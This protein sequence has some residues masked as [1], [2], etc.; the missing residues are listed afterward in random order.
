MPESLQNVVNR[1]IEE[2]MRSVNT[3]ASN[4]SIMNERIRQQNERQHQI[5]DSLKKIDAILIDD[6]DGLRTRIN[7]ILDDIEN[8]NKYNTESKKS[9]WSLRN[10]I[11]LLLSNAIVG[12]IVY[13]ITH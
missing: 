10:G 8:M 7:S 2:L 9:L 12:T 6:N 3:V 5:M 13:F 4:I 11:V 1:L